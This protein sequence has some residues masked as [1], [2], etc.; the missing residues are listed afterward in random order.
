MG[1]GD[2]GGR[3]EVSGEVELPLAGGNGGRREGGRCREGDSV[4]AYGRG[5]AGDDD[6]ARRGTQEDRGLEGGTGGKLE[7]EGGTEAKGGI[8]GGGG[9]DMSDAG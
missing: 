7:V 6:G 5:T 1:G 2:G 8:G 4:T 9:E 3:G